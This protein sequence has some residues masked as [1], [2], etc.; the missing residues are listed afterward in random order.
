MKLR[1]SFSYCHVSVRDLQ[2][3][4]PE[5][6]SAEQ[7]REITNRS[8]IHKRGNWETEHYNSVL[9]TIRPL[10]FISTRHRPFII[11]STTPQ[12]KSHLCT[13]SV[14]PEK[15]LCGLSPSLQIHV[16]VSDLYIPRFGPHIFRSKIGRPNCGNLD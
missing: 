15:A 7:S 4:F 6:S 2:Y 10:S 13:V 16:S 11:L 5:R 1:V 14:F 3:I 9:E 12:R 8:Q